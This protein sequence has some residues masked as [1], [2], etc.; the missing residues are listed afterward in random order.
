MKQP[1]GIMD[2]LLWWTHLH[3]GTKFTYADLPIMIQH[4]T[5]LCGLL[6]WNALVVHVTDNMDLFSAGDVDLERLKVMLDVILE[7]QLQPEVR[8]IQNNLFP[9]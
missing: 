7:H 4:D 9:F 8:H 3:S 5:F 1:K 6:A 2:V